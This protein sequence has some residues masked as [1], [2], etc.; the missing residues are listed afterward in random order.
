VTTDEQVIQGIS[1]HLETSWN[2]YESVSFASAFAEDATFIHIFGGTV[3]R[4][5]YYRGGPPAHLRDN[6]QKQPCQFCAR[7]HPLLA[8]GCSSGIPPECK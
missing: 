5:A 8:P 2:R 6:L 7:E 1:Q 3:G 4:A